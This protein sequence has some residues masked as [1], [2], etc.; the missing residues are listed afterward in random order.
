MTPPLA[1]TCEIIATS[2]AP[3][4]PW[5]A[6]V[7]HVLERLG[8][9]LVEAS[10]PALD[11][12]RRCDV[13]KLIVITHGFARSRRPDYRRH[14]PAHGRPGFR[15]GAK[16]SIRGRDLH[17]LFRGRGGVASK[18][19]RPLT[20]LRSHVRRPAAAGSCLAAD[21]RRQSARARPERARRRA[22]GRLDAR[23]ATAHGRLLRRRR[24]GSV[25]LG[26]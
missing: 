23:A 13:V 21:Q 19:R 26:P 16:P 24:R 11:A 5:P 4:A 7:P 25:S 3:R 6:A 10:G 2:R 22:A 20:F 18:S 17:G 15:G 14:E 1:A 8:Q 12:G 9:Q